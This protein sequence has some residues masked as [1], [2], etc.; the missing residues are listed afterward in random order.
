MDDIITIVNN[1]DN[2]ESLAI[3]GN[4]F[5]DYKYR[6]LSQVPKLNHPYCAFWELDAEE[7]STDDI[8]KTR[9]NAIEGEILRFQR[10][11][12]RKVLT[13]L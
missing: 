12:F 6:L 5:G 3:S 7:I 2:L 1:C 4:K 8:V 10:N 11:I 9:K 13:L